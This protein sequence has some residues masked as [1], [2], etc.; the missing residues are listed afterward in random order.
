MLLPLSP[1]VAACTAPLHFACR[2]VRLA[3]VYSM[4]PSGTVPSAPLSSVAFVAPTSEDLV[5]AVFAGD[6]AVERQRARFRVVRPADCVP[7]L[8][9]QAIDPLLLT[10]VLGRELAPAWVPL[11]ERYYADA[12][13]RSPATFLD[14]DRAWDLQR[15][16]WQPLVDDAE[17]DARPAGP[18]AD[19]VSPERGPDRDAALP[20]GRAA[21]GRGRRAASPASAAAEPS[22]P[23]AAAAGAVSWPSAAG[24]ALSEL[25]PDPPLDPEPDDEVDPEVD[26]DSPPLPPLAAEADDPRALAEGARV[27]RAGRYGLAVLEAARRPDFDLVTVFDGCLSQVD[28]ESH[29]ES[30]RFGAAS[31]QR[32]PQRRR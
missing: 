15:R 11:L 3:A 24:P 16:R 25:P 30:F 12:R 13:R 27:P 23:A 18:P 17:S 22:L 20:A 6:D 4:C 7:R 31:L 8:L 32:G 21:V 5:A 28:G 1:P 2:A 14:F 19:S 10:A 26:D 29:W 9:V